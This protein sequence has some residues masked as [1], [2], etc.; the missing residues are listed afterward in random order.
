MPD[1]MLPQVV[2]DCDQPTA[3][4]RAEIREALRGKGTAP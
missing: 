3:E 1:G 2:T 4:Q